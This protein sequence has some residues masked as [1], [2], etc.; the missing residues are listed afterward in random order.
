MIFPT[1][2]NSPPL[3]DE[4]LPRLPRF[5]RCTVISTKPLPS[6]HT[7]N[8]FEALIRKSFKRNKGCFLNNKQ[9]KRIDVVKNVNF[10]SPNSRL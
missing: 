4:D 8:S 5:K 9:K 7:P 1:L 10:T 3:K 2:P 6:V